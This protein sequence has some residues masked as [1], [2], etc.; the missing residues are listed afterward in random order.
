M[1][2]TKQVLTR[3]WAISSILA[4]LV[5]AVLAWSDLRLK[6]LS[7]FGTADLQVFATAAQYRAAFLVWP[8]L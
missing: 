5:F 8:S 7:G 6:S 4:A 2:I 1:R 3:R